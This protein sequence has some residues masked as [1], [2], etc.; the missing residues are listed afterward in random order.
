HHRL[1]AVRDDRLVRDLHAYV[2]ERLEVRRAHAV[3]AAH[4]RAPRP[5]EL[6][7]RRKARPADADEPELPPVHGRASAISSSATDCAASGRAV[8]S[9][10][11][12]IFA[13]R[14]LS[15]RSSSRTMIAP[16]ARTKCCAFAAW[17]SPVANG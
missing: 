16:P 5:R 1:P 13:S 12:R 4:L 3:P 11:S 15:S 7:V 14:G 10:A 6:R 17:W 9:I 2:R 8:R